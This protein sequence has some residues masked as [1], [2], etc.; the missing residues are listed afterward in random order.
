MIDPRVQA[1]C[2][3]CSVVGC[4]RPVR[5]KGV[6]SKHYARLRAHGTPTGGTAERSST[7][8]IEAFLVAM[9]EYDGEKCLIWPFATDT[10]G[11]GRVRIKGRLLGAHRLACEMEHGPAPR[12]KPEAAHSCANGA[13]GCVNR[14]HLRWASRVENSTDMVVHGNSARGAANFH[15]KL[16]VDDVQ[17]IRAL[18]GRLLQRELAEMFGVTQSAISLIY[19]GD[20]WGWLR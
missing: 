20:N 19:K 4:R 11:Y 10:N 14:R 9:R 3:E 18:K 5:C 6:C 2:E 15:T 7:K 16:S 1:L 13:G 8:A 12:G 17:R